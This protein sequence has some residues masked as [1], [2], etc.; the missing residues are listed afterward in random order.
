MEG[1][2]T[3]SKAIMQHPKYSCIGLDELVQLKKRSI[4]GYFVVEECPYFI[5]LTSLKKKISDRN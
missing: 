1:T 2:L 3:I 5:W 4:K